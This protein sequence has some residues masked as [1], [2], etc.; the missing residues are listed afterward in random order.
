MAGPERL[1]T[2]A[3]TVSLKL[4]SFLLWLGGAFVVGVVVGAIIF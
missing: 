3:K 2:I 4:T 1:V